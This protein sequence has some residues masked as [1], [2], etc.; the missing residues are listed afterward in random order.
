M[1]EEFLFR[2]MAEELGLQDPDKVVCLR[3]TFGQKKATIEAEWSYHEEDSKHI[4]E[5]MRRFSL[6]EELTEEIRAQDDPPWDTW[7][8]AED[9]DK[10]LVML[11]GKAALT[12]P[13]HTIV[14]RQFSIAANDLINMTG[15]S[16]DRDQHVLYEYIR[17]IDR[18]VTDGMIHPSKAV[19]MLLEACRDIDRWNEQNLYPDT[20]TRM[21]ALWQRLDIMFGQPPRGIRSG[22]AAIPPHP[23]HISQSKMKRVTGKS[24]GGGGQG[25]HPQMITVSP[26]LYEA[27]KK[28]TGMPGDWTIKQA[29]AVAEAVS[30]LKDPFPK[31]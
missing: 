31:G 6:Q 5:V 4:A 23:P 11:L 2:R 28:T 8:M 20:V 9:R 16:L 1:K 26:G 12:Q 30:L 27:M 22:P 13:L 29:Q 19:T 17:L 14:W 21:D 10:A 7:E 3:I 15:G 25:S 24:K 18:L